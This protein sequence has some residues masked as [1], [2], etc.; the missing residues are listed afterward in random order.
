M[1]GGGDL[2]TVLNLGMQSLTGVFP[3]K[4]GRPGR[5]SG[6]WNWC[7]RRAAACCS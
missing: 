1:G 2:L 5:V 3:K 4:Q 7:G 6:L